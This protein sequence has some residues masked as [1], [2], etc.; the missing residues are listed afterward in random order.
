MSDIEDEVDSKTARNRP[1]QG[2]SLFGCFSDMIPQKI[3][4]NSP[5]GSYT[6]TSL[7]DSTLPLKRGGKGDEEIQYQ[8]SVTNYHR[9]NNTDV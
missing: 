4:K 6:K 2:S 9:N 3:K 8:E 1:E 5:D 7:D